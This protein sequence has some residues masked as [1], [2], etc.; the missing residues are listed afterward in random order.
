MIITNEKKI[1]VNSKLGLTTKRE[2]CRCRCIIITFAENDGQ[3]RHA[4][5]Q[6]LGE[7]H[8]MITIYHA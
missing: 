6:M 7:M 4:K 1:I 2:Y 5:R 3:D 8:V